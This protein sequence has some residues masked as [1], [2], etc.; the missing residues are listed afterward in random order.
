MISISFNNET[1]Q[2]KSKGVKSLSDE[3]CKLHDEL[4]QNGTKIRAIIPHFT[5]M[6][7][8]A[9]RERGHIQKLR[10]EAGEAAQKLRANKDIKPVDKYQELKFLDGIAKNGKVGE[11]DE[12]LLTNLEEVL[13][14][15]TKNFNYFLTRM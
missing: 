15:V 1:P 11:L 14:S 4:K 13:G 5:E 12:Q 2:T 7:E 8:F 3:V 6:A 10:K 9:K